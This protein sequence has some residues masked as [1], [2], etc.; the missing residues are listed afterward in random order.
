MHFHFILKPSNLLL[1]V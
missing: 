1:E